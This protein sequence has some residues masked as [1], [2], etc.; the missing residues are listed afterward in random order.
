ML[1][2]FGQDLQR[3]IISVLTIMSCCIIIKINIKISNA[4]KRI[5]YHW[6]LIVIKGLRHQIP[7]VSH[8]NSSTGTSPFWF[9]NHSVRARQR[10]VQALRYLL[11]WRSWPQKDGVRGVKRCLRMRSSKT[12]RWK[13]I[14]VVRGIDAALHCDHE[15]LWVYLVFQLHGLIFRLKAVLG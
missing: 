13:V 2:F 14:E 11:T 7:L 4:L 5:N 12:A 8:W 6:F 15:K 10:A 3:K 9:L 1:F